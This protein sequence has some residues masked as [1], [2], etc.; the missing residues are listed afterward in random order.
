MWKQLAELDLVGLLLPP[1]YGGSGM[2]ALEG[3]VLYEELGRALAPTPHFPSAVLCGG[4]LAR[5][6]TDEQRRRWLASLASG[7]I[8]VV[9][10]WFEPDNSCRPAGVQMRD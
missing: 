2:G 5:A 9:P 6:G 10:A 1:E 3:V 4:L 7:D 8:V